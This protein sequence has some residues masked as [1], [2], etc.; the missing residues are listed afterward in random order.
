MGTKRKP[1]GKEFLYRII[2]IYFFLAIL[3]LLLWA[4]LN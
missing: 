3:G 1:S 4:L 2:A